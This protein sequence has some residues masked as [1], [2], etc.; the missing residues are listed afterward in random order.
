MACWCCGPCYCQGDPCKRDIRI[1][2]AWGG[3]SLTTTIITLKTGFNNRGDLDCNNLGQIQSVSGTGTLALTVVGRCDEA[4]GS[5]PDW[6]N[7]TYSIGLEV[8][9]SIGNTGGRQRPMCCHQLQNSRNIALNGGYFQGK[10]ISFASANPQAHNPGYAPGFRS[11]WEFSFPDVT[12]GAVFVQKEHD[13]DTT[14]CAGLTQFVAAWI[15]TA[16]TLSIL[17]GKAVEDRY[18]SKDFYSIPQSPFPPYGPVSTHESCLECSQVCG[19]P[20]P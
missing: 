15:N 19:N 11:N 2:A 18:C 3:L 13:G 12:Q 8:G 6:A 20:L 17:Y 9:G 10:G 4:A 7:S 16:P 5:H 1:L 14:N